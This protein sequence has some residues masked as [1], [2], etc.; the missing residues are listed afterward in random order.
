MIRNTN[1]KSPR[2]SYSSDLRDEQANA[3]RTRI[4][5]ALVRTLS[6]GVATLSIP[7]VAHEAGVSVPTIY[8]HFGSKQGLVAALGPHVVS[9]AGLLPAALPESLSEFEPMI[10]QL[11][12]NLERGLFR[13][14]VQVV[15]FRSPS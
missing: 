3:T 2:R 6:E 11:F 5:E 12:R 13:P 10:R 1:V 8:R 7:G 4:L 9:R 14:R 15:P